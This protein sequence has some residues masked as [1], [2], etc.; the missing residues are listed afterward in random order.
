MLYVYFVLVNTLIFTLQTAL[1]FA[2]VDLSQKMTSI[3][4]IS[5]LGLGVIGFI[6]TVA[7]LARQKKPTI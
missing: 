4:G 3:S 7:P 5:I 2:G 1:F 6:A